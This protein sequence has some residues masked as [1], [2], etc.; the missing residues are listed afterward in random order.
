MGDI[1][2]HFLDLP[3]WV[4]GIRHPSKVTATSPSHPTPDP[5]ITPDALLVRWDFPAVKLAPKGV[6]VMW[7][8][9]PHKPEAI[10][11]WG[12]PEKLQAEG[13]MF[14]GEKGMLCS[15]YRQHVLLPEA[16]YKDY[17]RPEKT[18]PSSPGHPAEWINAGLANDP[19]KTST[20]FSY[21]G[22]LSEA[23][24]LGPIAYR[25]GKALEWDAQAMRFTN[26]TATNSHLSYRYRDGWSL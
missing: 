21:G 23:A 13:M 4:L 2:C 15:N 17:Q 9:P 6:P 7:Y 8:D 10:G 25:V 11:S 14:I 20:P 18:I 24:L 26:D 19:S 12:L 16:Q 22:P 3:F 1:G 5:D